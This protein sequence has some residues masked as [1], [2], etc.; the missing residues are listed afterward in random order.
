LPVAGHRAADLHKLPLQHAYAEAIL[1]LSCLWE[2]QPVTYC[3][4][5]LVTHEIGL[6]GGRQPYGFP[7]CSATWSGSRSTKSSRLCTASARQA[8]L[9]RRLR[10]RDILS[11]EDVASPP[12]VTLE[13]IPS[14][15]E[16]AHPRCASWSSHH[17][18]S[19]SLSAPTDA[20]RG[21]PAQETSRSI[22][23]V[24]STLGTA[25]QAAHGLGQLGSVQLGAAYGRVIKRYDMTESPSRSSHPPW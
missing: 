6:I 18:N 19:S 10:P 15:E 1:G 12:L 21:S 23:L 4:N 14:P 16:D 20:A 3:A 5:L 7:S 25:C 13:V 2:N 17:W 11:P 24:Q 22:H 8:H 9:H